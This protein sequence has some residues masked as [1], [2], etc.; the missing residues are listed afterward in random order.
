MRHTKICRVYWSNECVRFYDVRRGR[1]WDMGQMASEVTVH[2]WCQA[3]GV[4]FIVNE[5]EGACAS[6][7]AAARAPRLA[8]SLNHS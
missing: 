1:W 3:N 5:P 7:E 4:Q 2:A 8:F 6:R